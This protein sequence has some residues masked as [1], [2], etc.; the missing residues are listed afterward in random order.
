ML[1]IIYNIKYFYTYTTYI[2]I[3]L[4]NYLSVIYYYQQIC[5][6]TSDFD[7]YHIMKVNTGQLLPSAVSAIFIGW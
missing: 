6:V 7:Q 1:T 4:H 5:E 2:N 3:Y